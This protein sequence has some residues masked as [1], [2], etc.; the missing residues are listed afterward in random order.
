MIRKTL[1]LLALALPALMLAPLAHAETVD[2]I[3]AK[4]YEAM[5]GL[6]K[7]K[8]LNSMRVTGTMGIGPGT[9]SW[10]RDTTKPA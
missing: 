5:G 2:E 6:A 4:H 8:A 3:L 9:S 10:S 1:L 7:L